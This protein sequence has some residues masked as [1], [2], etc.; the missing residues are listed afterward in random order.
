MVTSAWK[1]FT[2]VDP[3]KQYVAYAAYVENKSA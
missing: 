3:S 1:T 2:E